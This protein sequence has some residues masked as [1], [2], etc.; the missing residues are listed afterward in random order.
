MHSSRSACGGQA[1]RRR[2]PAIRCSTP[3]RAFSTP[4]NGSGGTTAMGRLGSCKLWRTPNLDPV[5]TSARSASCFKLG[6]VF[7]L[8]LHRAPTLNTCCNFHQYSSKSPHLHLRSCNTRCHILRCVESFLNRHLS[9]F[10]CSVIQY[11]L[12]G[13]KFSSVPAS[14]VKQ[15]ITAPSVHPIGFCAA[16]CL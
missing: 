9:H 16:L 2:T 5:T 6:G 13:Q 1:T 3:R 8:S 11:C 10:L 14:N 4:S 7:F 15:A 12:L